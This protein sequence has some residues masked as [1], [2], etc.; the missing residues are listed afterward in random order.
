L[1]KQT[2]PKMGVSTNS[3]QLITPYEGMTA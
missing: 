3:S 1:Q 2:Q